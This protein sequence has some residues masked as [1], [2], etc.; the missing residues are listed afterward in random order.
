M[1]RRQGPRTHT[2]LQLG[3]DVAQC[4]ERLVQDGDQGWVSHV[5]QD[6]QCQGHLSLQGLLALLDLSKETRERTR[7]G[8]VVGGQGRQVKGTGLGTS[9]MQRD[10]GQ[11]RSHSQWA[12]TVDRSWDC[13]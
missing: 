7:E 13:W 9:E 6:L 3:V 2:G 8:A 12:H 5:P 10:R 4:V 1:W 11:R